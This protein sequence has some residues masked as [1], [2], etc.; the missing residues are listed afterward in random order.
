MN[1]FG[2][3][4]KTNFSFLRLFGAAARAATA[5]GTGVDCKDLEGPLTAVVEAGVCTDGNYDFTIEESSDDSTYTAITPYKGTFATIT[6]AADE[7]VQTVQ[8]KRSKRYVRGVITESSAG[9]TGVVCAML[10]IGR[11]KSV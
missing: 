11:K 4:L 6:S 3:D 1:P 8:F 5:N 10:L 7:L 2:N 9:S